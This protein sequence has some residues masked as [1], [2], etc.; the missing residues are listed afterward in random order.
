LKTLLI[1]KSAVELLAGLALALFPSAVVP[2]ITGSPLDV[3]SG[4]VVGR[5]AGA[6]L[7]ALGIACW[8][9]RDDGRSRAAA[10]LIGALLFYDAAVVIILL[11]ARFGAELSGVL[12]WPAVSLHSGLGIWSLLCLRKNTRWPLLA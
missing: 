6:A 3:P 2:L 10:A 12:L 5:L 4:I 8:L 1:V 11:S 7:F 9:A